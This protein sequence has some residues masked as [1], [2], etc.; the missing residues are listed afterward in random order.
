MYLYMGDSQEAWE[1]VNPKIKW[2]PI[3]LNL[4]QG[5]QPLAGRSELLFVN[6]GRLHKNLRVFIDPSES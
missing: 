5:Y 4:I 2:A 3:G 1:G 6:S